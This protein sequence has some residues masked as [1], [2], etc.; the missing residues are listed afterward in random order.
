VDRKLLL[1]SQ[2][3]PDNSSTRA[4]IA[5]SGWPTVVAWVGI[6]LAN[7]LTE[8]HAHGVLHRD[9]KPANVLLSADGVPKLADFNVSFAGVAG[10]AG[11]AASF[12][13]SIG[14]MSPEHLKAIK[15]SDPQSQSTVNEASDLYSLAVLLWELWQGERPF[16]V[17]SRTSSWSEAI[18][19]QLNAREL[20]FHSPR[21]TGDASERVLE[22]VL[23]QTLSSNPNQRP[24]SGAEMAGRL[25]L[26]LY[27]KAAEL[28]DVMSSRKRSWIMRRSPWIVATAIILTPNVLG[29]FL[30]FQY[31]YNEV[32]TEGMKD[33]LV[34]VSWF[35]NPTFF[36]MG[37]GL[38]IYFA[39]SVMHA[40]QT[41]Q[42]GELASA[43]D[44]D[45][46]LELGNRAAIIG[47]TLWLMGGAV[48]PVSLSMMYPDFTLTQAVHFMLSSIICGAIAM[49]Y[50]FY[51][52][53][54]L[55]TL[56]Y[57]PFFLA[58][59][60][61]DGSVQ[62]RAS[63]V[64]KQSEIYLLIAAL[65]PF[66]AVALLILNETTERIFLFVAVAA[67]SIGLVASFFTHRIL[68]KWWERMSEVLE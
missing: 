59:S 13:G 10:R 20:D 27:P 52:M 47:G 34:L 51:A 36:P 50:P 48:F 39:I 4:M 28:F 49:I 1:T 37:A 54:L 62:K 55:A 7:A 9:V 22:K 35:T 31:N 53:A 33:G 42:A 40:I 6:Q 14:Y 68:Q 24:S 46:T 56:V 43:Q 21:R 44:I 26:A 58:G 2:S 38:I 23:R 63:R 19:S 66:L 5:R 3:V 29:G 17:P 41:A 15:N 11:A 8:A 60:M 57:Y 25:K 30:N 32:V 45:D 12:G 16:N 18:A 61:I 65:I 64:I 67:G